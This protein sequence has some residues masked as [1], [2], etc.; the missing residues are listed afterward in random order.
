MLEVT[1]LFLAVVVGVPAML[2]C[3]STIFAAVTAPRGRYG[4]MRFDHLALG[5]FVAMGGLMVMAIMAWLTREDG[6]Y[7]D[8]GSGLIVFAAIFGAGV[9]ILGLGPFVPW[10]LGVLGQGGV[11]LPAAF[12]LAARHLA[13][14]RARTAPA[15]ATTMAA[16]AVTIAVAIT[17]A[18]GTAQERQNYSPRARPGALVV[19]FSTED[20]ATARVAVQQVLPGVPVAQGLGSRWPANFNVRTDYPS[21]SE[22]YVGDQALLRYL[23]GNPSFPYDEGRA[24]TVTSEDGQYDTVEI[25]YYSSN[26]P[27]DP[28][29]GKV[30]PTITVEPAAPGVEGV[31][32]PAKIL[33][34]MGAQ[35]DAEAL[36]VDPSLHRV[37]EADRDRLQDRLGDSDEAYLEQGFQAPTGWRY[38]AGP[39]ALIALAGA[40]VATIRSNRLLR[41]PNT[42][43]S[44]A[45]RVLTACRAALA[46]A[47][48][49]VMGAFAGCVIGLLLAWPF[50]TSVDW[51]VPP[52]VSFET[53]W[54]SIGLMTAAIPLIAAVIALFFRQGKR[55]GPRE[56]GR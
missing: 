6:H 51:E 42:G 20:A 14:Q 28:K 17:T 15:V 31:F 40:L 16:T 38:V 53:P 24:V 55:A 7:D 56:R 3:G 49:T 45:A 27:D 19:A 22:A 48:G 47:C 33:Q 10:L 43:S 1:Y 46:G 50:T 12:R 26:N 4:R 18:A 52:R 11:W 2:A 5:A 30:I 35:L 9:F 25:D 23:T 34:G 39:M 21:T 13:Y 41:R 29:V 44:S 8:F 32:I 37:S 36:I 54:A